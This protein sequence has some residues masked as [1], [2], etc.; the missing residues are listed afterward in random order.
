MWPTLPPAARAACYIIP[1]AAAV[2]RSPSGHMGACPRHFISS[3]DVWWRAGSPEKVRKLTLRV[4]PHRTQST[5]LTEDLSPTAIFLLPVFT[6]GRKKSRE[7]AITR[8]YL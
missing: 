6:T 5:I 1:A 3:M 8:A 2:T 7:Q 4:P